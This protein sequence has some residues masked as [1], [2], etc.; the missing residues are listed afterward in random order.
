[1]STASESE[2]GLLHAAVARYLAEKIASGEATASD[3]TNAL[4]MLKDN[5]ITCA[6]DVDNALGGLQRALEEKGRAWVWGMFVEGIGAF[7]VMVAAE[8]VRDLTDA[9]RAYYSG[10]TMGMYGSHSGN[11]SYTLNLPEL[12]P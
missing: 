11:L 7:N 10:R 4:K 2:L 8:H 6:A 5:N 9:E 1:M 3:V 12:Q